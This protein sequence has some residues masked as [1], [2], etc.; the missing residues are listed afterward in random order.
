MQCCTLW[1]LMRSQTAL[2]PAEMPRGWKPPERWG[3][4][5]PKLLCIDRELLTR[6]LLSMP[7][8]V[9]LN[10]LRRDLSRR[11][12]EVPPR[13]QMLT[14]IPLLQMRK[15][16]LQQMRRPPLQVLRDL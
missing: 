10:L 1:L 5:L 6:V 14:P 4:K 3:L 16:L 7:L 13:P 2:K 12:A 9:L 11:A 15:L 8:D